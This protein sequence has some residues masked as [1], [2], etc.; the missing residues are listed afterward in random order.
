MMMR[1]AIIKI[2]GLSFEWI[3]STI[4]ITAVLFRVNGKHL[5]IMIACEIHKEGSVSGTR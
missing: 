5:A 4:K 1:G 2:Y 3:Q